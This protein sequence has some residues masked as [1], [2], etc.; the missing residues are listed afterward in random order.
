MS[1][2]DSLAEAFLTDTVQYIVEEALPAQRLKVPQALV[3]VRK[4]GADMSDYAVSVCEMEF[5]KAL[6]PAIAQQGGVVA[7]GK[8]L[9]DLKTDSAFAY[10]ANANAM[11]ALRAEQARQDKMRQ[12]RAAHGMVT[13]AQV[14]SAIAQY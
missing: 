6:G 2:K 8:L 12:A 10:R 3:D 7:S 4:I 14:H 9:E 5:K 13:R 1:F 11:D